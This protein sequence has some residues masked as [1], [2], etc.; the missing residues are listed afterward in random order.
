MKNLFGEE[1]ADMPKKRNVDK[2]NLNAAI[3]DILVKYDVLAD[4]NR[5]IIASTDGT[6]TYYDKL[7]PRAEI[8][9]SN[10]NEDYAQW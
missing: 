2:A 4:D 8:E 6:R 1:Y 9:I 7:N 5:N 10:F 3:H